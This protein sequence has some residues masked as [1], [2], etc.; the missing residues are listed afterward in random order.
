MQWPYLI[1]V[2]NVQRLTRG[3]HVSHNALVPLQADTTVG[4]FL[5]CGAFSYIKQPADQELS[6]GAVLTHQEQRVAVSGD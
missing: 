3:C 1:G 2:L 6:V 4:C 5:Q